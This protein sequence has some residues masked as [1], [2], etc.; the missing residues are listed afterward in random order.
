MCEYGCCIIMCLYA[1]QICFFSVCLDAPP[2]LRRERPT[3][4]HHFCVW[5]HV[6]VCM[7]AVHMCLYVCLYVCCMCV[8]M[9]AY[10]LVYVCLYVCVWLLYVCMCVCSVCLSDSCLLVC[11]WLRLLRKPMAPP[12]GLFG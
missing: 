4:P 11:L 1:Y 7:C 10:V 2:V 5:E 3:L 9:C 8:C 12:I 6:C